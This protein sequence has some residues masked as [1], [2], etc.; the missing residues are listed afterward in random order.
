MAQNLNVYAQNTSPAKTGSCNHGFNAVGRINRLHHKWHS[1][2]TLYTQN[3][4]NT[5]SRR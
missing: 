3:D 1:Q 5:K 4:T 2:S